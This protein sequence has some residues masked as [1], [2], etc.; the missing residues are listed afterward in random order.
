MKCPKCGKEFTK[1]KRQIYC[2]EKCCDIR[3][4]TIENRSRTLQD[5]FWEK[6]E[7]LGNDD[8]WLW[9]AGINR[10]YKGYGRFW[11]NGSHV[12]AHRVSW[13]F[14]YGPIENGL[15][16]LHKCD[17]PRCVNPNH[18]FLGTHMDNMVDMVNKKRYVSYPGERCGKAK[19]KTEDVRNIR[20]TYCAG[21]VSTY[22]LARKFH[23]SQHTISSIL[24]RQTWRHLE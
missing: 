18:L 9:K 7:I 22:E 21:N 3:W 13:I 11:I 16:C 4:S 2:S 24:H 14:T 23:V 20:I 8:C 19:L 1:I 6:V 17:N 15:E 12:V 5:R 10:K